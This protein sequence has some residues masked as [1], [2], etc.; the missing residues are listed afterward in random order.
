LT[1]YRS[2]GVV[3]ST[4][5]ALSPASWS[6]A[7]VA[8]GWGRRERMGRLAAAAR[9]RIRRRGDTVRTL[10][11]GR[12]AR[13]TWKDVPHP[14]PP[15]AYAAV[16]T[17]LAM[18]TCD[19]D[20]PIALGATPFPL[21]LSLGHEC[22]AEVVSVGE[23]VGTVRPGD[24]VVVPFQI[25]C[26]TC[27][28]CRIGRSGNC[29]R[30]PPLSMY[31][32]GLAGGLWG[33]AIADRLTVPYADAM[34]V[35]LPAGVSPAAA[36]SVADTM[37]DA[38]RHIAPHVD[39]VRE[40]PDGPSVVIVGA[41]SARSLFGASVPLYA[42]MI[43]QALLPGVDVV[44]GD[45]RPFV[46]AHAERLGLTAVPVAALR[47]RQAPLV[48]D[49]SASPRGLARALRSTAPDGHCTCAGLL[50]ASARVPAGLMFGRNAT[51]SIARSHVRA[52]IPGVLDLIA[53]GRLHPEPVTTTL[54]PLDESPAALRHHVLDRD[55]K[56]VLL[57]A[58]Q[59]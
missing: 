22:V 58:P 6:A 55:I 29:R 23:H 9:A 35:P 57:R 34:L 36:A 14:P 46:R 11:A 37:S 21:P 30:V 49:S 19:L 5:T 18:A 24:R 54:A 2:R 17:P 13:L 47:H 39:R 33:G 25:S 43:A 16:V 51:L 45:E 7:G 1:A 12:G 52:A 4:A 38:Y 53:T 15:D 32:F 40:H 27:P 10:V 44:I 28:A 50:H 56:T 8:L 26:G 42:A 59:S 41:V 3:R 31:G 48:L 20:R